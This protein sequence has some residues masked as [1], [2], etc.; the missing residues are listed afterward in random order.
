MYV[1]PPAVKM[2]LNQSGDS[3]QAKQ[4][5]EGIKRNAKIMQVWQLKSG[6]EKNVAELHPMQHEYA[7]SAQEKGTSSWLAAIPIRRHGFALT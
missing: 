3:L 4:Q 7:A 5:Q 1:H 6:A 2:I